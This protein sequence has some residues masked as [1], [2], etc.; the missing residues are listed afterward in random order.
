MKKF[1][2]LDTYVAGLNAKI[3]EKVSG[4]DSKLDGILISLSKRNKSEHTTVEREAQLDQLI[5]IRIK[6]TIE[7]V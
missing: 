4:L 6:H 3:D 1:E 7:E 5:S 2:S